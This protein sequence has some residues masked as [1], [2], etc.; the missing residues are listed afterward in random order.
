MASPSESM[1][2][3]SA[4]LPTPTQ[5]AKQ[6][7][8]DAKRQYTL[9]ARKVKNLKKESSKSVDAA[10]RYREARLAGKKAQEELTK[11]KRGAGIT[12]KKSR[13]RDVATDSDDMTGVKMSSSAGIK[14]KTRE[15]K[16]RAKQ[17]LP[18]SL[19]GPP[20][21]T[22][23]YGW[24]VNDGDHELDRDELRAIQSK[25]DMRLLLPP[26][27][28]LEAERASR[29]ERRD[30]QKHLALAAAAE[31]LVEKVMADEKKNNSEQ[32]G[33]KAR[34][35]NTLIMGELEGLEEEKNSSMGKVTIADLRREEVRK[36]RARAVNAHPPEE[37]T[38]Q[39]NAD[40]DDIA[41]KLGL[42]SMGRRRGK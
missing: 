14:K 29:A 10:K 6:R 32:A 39:E 27:Q 24:S 4:P 2:L 5:E 26:P 12:S 42:V 22:G 40:I 13:K 17:P 31:E 16:P 30:I 23:V 33:S 41:E 1:D 36:E 18:K 9:T 37:R 11:L 7:Y 3:D 28:M 8:L 19:S 25:K 21:G 38:V 34:R 20:T 15:R 35:R